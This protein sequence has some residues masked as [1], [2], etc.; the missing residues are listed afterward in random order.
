MY[1]RK[2]VS[3]I[4]ILIFFLVIACTEKSVQITAPL[5]NINNDEIIG[6][7][8]LTKI[9]YQSG[10]NNI[11]VLPEQNG[12]SMTLKFFDTNT[13]QMTKFENGSTNIDVFIWNKLGSVVEIIDEDSNWETLKCELC[14]NILLL[15][16]GFEI[17]EGEIVLASFVFEKDRQKKFAKN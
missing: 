17:E 9:R 3:V 11:T 6:T 4:V 1:R 15:E 12:I 5:N 13:G 16:Y 8:V 7:W 14:E 10:G 2:L